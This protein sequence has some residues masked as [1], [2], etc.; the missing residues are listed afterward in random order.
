MAEE[1]KSTIPGGV[2]A[3]VIL[4]FIFAPTLWNGMASIF[5]GIG[6]AFNMQSQRSPGLIIILLIVAIVYFKGKKKDEA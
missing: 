6:N 3:I 4:S 2:V 5:G 1:K